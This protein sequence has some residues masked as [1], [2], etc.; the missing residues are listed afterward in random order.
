MT[1]EKPYSFKKFEMIYDFQ[2][3]IMNFWNTNLAMA[4]GIPEIWNAV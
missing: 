4:Y 3:S 2:L 1:F